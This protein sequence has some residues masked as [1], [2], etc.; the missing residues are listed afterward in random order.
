MHSGDRVAR[1]V[2]RRCRVQGLDAGMVPPGRCSGQEASPDP[3]AVVLGSRRHGRAGSRP[4][5][6]QVEC[7]CL[8]GSG[9]FDD[10]PPTRYTGHLSRIWSGF[11][12]RAICGPRRFGGAPPDWAS[13]RRPTHPTGSRMVEEPSLSRP[14]GAFAGHSRPNA[15]LIEMSSMLL[16]PGWPAVAASGLVTLFRKARI[17]RCRAAPAVQGRGLVAG[18]RKVWRHVQDFGRRRGRSRGSTRPCPL[19]P[20]SRRRSCRRYRRGSCFGSSTLLGSVEALKAGCRRWGH[21]ARR[22]PRP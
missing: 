4:S 10:A 9:P 12:I 18:L 2:R 6:G 19:R 16:T 3:T 14:R 5:S 15:L 21:R 22:S 17:G 8:T 1:P 13:G 20:P 11:E 7:F